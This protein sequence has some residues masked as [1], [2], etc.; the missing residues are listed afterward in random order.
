L[1]SDSKFSVLSPSQAPSSTLSQTPSGGDPAAT[2]TSDLTRVHFEVTP[3]IDSSLAEDKDMVTQV[4]DAATL[5]KDYR[6]EKTSAIITNVKYNDEE[7]LDEFVQGS[8]TSP[9]QDFDHLESDLEDSL[10]SN[11]RK[12]CVEEL[13]TESSSEAIASET[14]PLPSQNLSNSF[15]ADQS[16]GSSTENVSSHPYTS[17]SSASEEVD[18]KNA[19]LEQAVSNSNTKSP[20]ITLDG[21]HQ[22][23]QKI[24][25]DK[26]HHEMSSV[27][28][29]VQ[30]GISIS[31]TRLTE[32]A[33]PV[34]KG[35]GSSAREER[36]E[37]PLSNVFDVYEK[38][39]EKEAEQQR[40]QAE[41]HGAQDSSTES[42][43]ELDELE[44][45]GTPSLTNKVLHGDL[46]EKETPSG[47]SFEVSELHE[48]IEDNVSDRV[49]FTG[50]SELDGDGEGSDGQV[51]ANQTQ[52]NLTQVISEVDEDCEDSGEI[53][54]NEA[55]DVQV[56]TDSGA[57]KGVEDGIGDDDD[58]DDGW[59]VDNRFNYAS[60]D[61]G[62]KVLQANKEA[63]DRSSVL[64]SSLDK[65]SISP[66]SADR[67]LVVELCEEIGVD[68]FQIVNAEY[69]SS[70]MQYIDVFGLEF[71]SP[72]VVQKV[73]SIPIGDGEEIVDTQDYA[74]L[75][76]FY[77]ENVRTVQTFMLD[78]ATLPAWHRILLFRL[79]GS[80]GNKYY[81]PVSM[82]KVYGTSMVEDAKELMN[83]HQTE[84]EIVQRTLKETTLT[85]QENERQPDTYTPSSSPG[86]ASSSTLL[87]SPS[88]SHATS[89]LDESIEEKEKFGKTPPVDDWED[90]DSINMQLQVEEIFHNHKADSS[91]TKILS[92]I[93]SL[94]SVASTSS[95]S[96]SSEKVDRKIP[97]K[98]VNDGSTEKGS[99]AGEEPGRV[100]G[101]RSHQSVLAF[102]TNAGIYGYLLF[103]SERMISVTV[104]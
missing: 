81:C 63:S 48:Y 79:R 86:S 61:C 68:S 76:T 55:E 90:F 10:S 29:N 3:G 103:D 50:E 36:I 101:K 26:E 69:F 30:D 44:N 37:S 71:Y 80:Y 94:K 2:Q 84:M 6:E 28:G 13:E 12:G 87:P 38:S 88:P 15:D 17:S 62:A 73:L 24:G 42:V 51:K 20:G 19:K 92:G 31:D 91:W 32:T 5:D 25:H 100:A 45:D 98:F 85:E 82:L 97:G 95:F 8:I 39:E 104:D 41:S 89:I 64:F 74:F 102:L 99:S 46:A 96:S 72:A 83:S 4:N 40:F 9:T 60:V 93:D 11:G 75:G 14:E 23:S 16:V 66:C 59:T 53:A 49:N 43:K 54:E 57:S 52:E 34:R 56:S 58:D 1:T 47:D 27:G 18:K 78:K 67:F 65:Y 33:S 70:T 21:I 22:H 35:E 7:K 77:A